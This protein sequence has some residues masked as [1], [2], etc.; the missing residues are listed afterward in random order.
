MSANAEVLWALVLHLALTGLPGVAAALFAA[1]RGLRS[2]PLILAL[3]LAVSG[4][5]A[6]LSFWAYFVDPTIGQIWAF[7][8]V[9]A[10]VE[11]IAW[12]LYKGGIDRDLLAELRVPLALW[13]LGSFFIVYL[14]F[15]H[16]GV[17]Q[18]LP[19]SSSRFSGQLPSDNDIPQFFANWFYENGHTRPVPEFP[20]EW[21]SSDRPPLQIGYVLSQ[22]TFGWD[23]TTLHYQVLC[24]VVQQLWIVGLWAVLCAARLGRRARALT[25]FAVLVSDVAIL[26]GFFVWPKLIAAAFLLGAVALVV[27]PEWERWR[28]DLRVAAVFAALCALAM[29]SHGSS[30]FAIVP[31][32]ALGALRGLPSPRWLGVALVVGIAFMAPWTAF[33]RYVDPPGDRLVKWQIGGVMEIDGRGA[34]ETIV[35]SYS[36]AGFDGVVDA[37]WENFRMMAGLPAAPDQLRASFDAAREGEWTAAAEI[38][39]GPRFFSLLPFLGILLIAP[40]AMLLARDRGRR[41]IEEWRFALFCFAFVLVGCLAWGLLMF[42]APNAITF[43]HVGSLA[44]PLLAI[45]GCVA[46][47]YAVSSRL[48]LAVVALNAAFVLLVYTPELTPLPG[49]SYS[50]LAAL[51]AAAA[52]AGFAFVSS[53][54][55]SQ[56]SDMPKPG[57]EVGT[58]AS[59]MSPAEHSAAAP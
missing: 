5:V 20:G 30:A 52:L 41:R 49:T 13:V 29:L 22:R 1:R 14:G 36:E 55:R 57:G 51:L 47:L 3:A 43:L 11:V 40:L 19:M 25:M 50:P 10:S 34:G 6:I 53:S 16:G 12:S 18:A 39:R 26:H 59:V 7:V 56:G 8:V 58:E 21:L 32:F 46:G 27:S 31:L 38:I 48:A 28:R 4:A 2:V 54:T 24:V 44:I 23:T 35:D 33:Q 42:G 15:L 37:K 9:F 45:C 17:D